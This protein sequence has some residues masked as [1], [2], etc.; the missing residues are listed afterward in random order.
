LSLFTLVFC[1]V[2]GLFLVAPLFS[3][4][5]VPLR[6]RVLLAVAISIC[7]LPIVA[8]CTGGGRC[9]AHARSCGGAAEAPTEAFEPAASGARPAV[10]DDMVG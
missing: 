8:A 10:P 5:G 9:R 1:R 6:A 7:L 4:G 2:G 3:R